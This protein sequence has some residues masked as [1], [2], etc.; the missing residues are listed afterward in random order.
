MLWF[1]LQIVICISLWLQQII[2]MLTTDKLRHFV[3]SKF[4]NCLSLDHQVCFHVLITSQQLMEAICHFSLE[5]VVPVTHEQNIIWSKT[6]L[7]CT[8]HEQTIVCRQLFAGY[9]LGSRPMKRKKK[10]TERK[11]MFK[12]FHLCARSNLWRVFYFYSGGMALGL[13]EFWYKHQTLQD[14]SDQFLIY[15]QAQFSNSRLLSISRVFPH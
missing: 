13:C 12:K 11:R 1:V 6:F 7:D 9:L 8:V 15:S 4:N 10:M 2:E 5:N 3:I 14:N